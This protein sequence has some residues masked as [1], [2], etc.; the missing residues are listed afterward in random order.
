MPSRNPAILKNVSLAL[1]LLIA[2]MGSVLPGHAGTVPV[3]DPPFAPAS[4]AP[5][6]SGFT[7]TVRGFGFVSGSVVNWNGSARTTALVSSSTLEASIGA[8]DVAHPGHCHN[9]SH[10]SKRP[11]LQRRIISHS[12]II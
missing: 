3:I 7:L 1:A 2:T 6:S 8:A 5:G 9:R 10:Q 11:R 12:K 4:V